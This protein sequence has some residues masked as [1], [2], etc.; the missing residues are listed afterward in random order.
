MRASHILQ[1]HTQ[2]I[3]RQLVDVHVLQCRAV[4]EVT[5]PC[6]RDD[7]SV[8][9]YLDQATAADVQCLIMDMLLGE[10]LRTYYHSLDEGLRPAEEALYALAKAEGVSVTAGEIAAARIDVRDLKNPSDV[11]EVIKANIEHLADITRHI[12]DKAP[13]HTGNVEAADNTLG[14]FYNNGWSKA[15]D[16][17]CADQ[18]QVDEAAPLDTEDADGNDQVQDAEP[19]QLAS[20]Q[21]S[22]LQVK[23]KPPT[24]A[25]SGPIIKTKKNRTVAVLPNSDLPADVQLAKVPKDE[26]APA[27]SESGTEI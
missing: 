22:K 26:P 11:M 20:S 19:A 21:R 6:E 14:Y 5:Y 10:G 24:P 27:A 16:A 25:T 23:A 17:A 8:C 12:I 1:F 7:E 4:V 9:A 2:P 18:V 15:D 3:L 13:H